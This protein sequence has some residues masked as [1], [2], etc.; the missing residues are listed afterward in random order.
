MLLPRLKPGE[1]G[2]WMRR[3]QRDEERGRL[4]GAGRAVGIANLTLRCLKRFHILEIVGETACPASG[5]TWATFFVLGAPEDPFVLGG[6]KLGKPFK[7]DEYKIAKA[8]Y[9]S[10]EGGLSRPNLEY[11]DSGARRKL[12]QMRDSYPE[13]GPYILF[14]GKRNGGNYRFGFPARDTK[15]DPFIDAELTH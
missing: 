3:V 5:R 9:Q 10:G 2:T 12:R 7:P 14:P 11:I 8:I 1:K 6:V 15:G 4:A 13:L